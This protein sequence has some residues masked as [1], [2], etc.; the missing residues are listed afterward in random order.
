MIPNNTIDNAIYH[1]GFYLQDNF[2]PIT[3]YQNLRTTLQEQY[4]LGL[5]K[6][7]KIG[8]TNNL[9]LQTSIRNDQIYWIDEHLPNTA[10]QIYFDALNKI[11]TLLNQSLFMGLHTIEAHF[12]IYNPGSFYKK[13]VDQF[14]STRDRRISCVYYLNENWQPEHGGELQLYNKDDTSLINIQPRGNRLICFKS[15][16]PH[17]VAI[18]HATRYSIASWFRVRA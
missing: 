3:H 5:F 8:K 4:Q 7:G 12:A 13:H 17:E 14:A 18:A 2:L 10:I 16:L 15:D 6:T 11:K 1:H 9:T